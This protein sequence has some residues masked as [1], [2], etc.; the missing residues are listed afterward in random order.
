M[1]LMQ[2]LTVGRSLKTV[3]N[4]PSPY[5]MDKAKLLPKF[6]GRQPG[7]EQGSLAGTAEPDL[8]RKSGPDGSPGSAPGADFPQPV[9]QGF[10]RKR[11]LTGWLAFRK[12]LRKSSPKT[13]VPVQT[14]LSLEAV[15]VVRNDLQDLEPAQKSGGKPARPESV[16]RP[17]TR[18][19]AGHWWARLQMRLFSRRKQD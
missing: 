15:R 3:K 14:E 2:L 13:S 19:V 1:S 10:E 9:V 7:E 11:V 8:P 18:S 4:A 5:K 6:A 16:F 12:K 17:R